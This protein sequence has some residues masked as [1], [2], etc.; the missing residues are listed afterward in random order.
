MKKLDSTIISNLQALATSLSSLE[1]KMYSEYKINL[2]TE[3]GDH[4]S[5]GPNIGEIRTNSFKYLE[6]N[7]IFLSLITLGLILF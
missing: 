2:K 3:N 6:T 7:F 4:I 5:I 1:G